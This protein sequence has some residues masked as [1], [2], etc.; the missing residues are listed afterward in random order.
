[1][2]F[3]SPPVI[4]AIVAGGL[5]IVGL[6]KPAWPITP[7]AVLLLAIAVLVMAAKG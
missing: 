6:F 2:N 1:M 4:L 7:V 5:A 3:S